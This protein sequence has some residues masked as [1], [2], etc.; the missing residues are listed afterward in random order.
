MIFARRREALRPIL[1]SERW[2]QVFESGEVALHP[3]SQ[4][5]LDA[6]TLE[7]PSVRPETG[8]AEAALPYLQR[9]SPLLGHAPDMG[10]APD[11]GQ[12]PDMTSKMNELV[13]AVSGLEA[14]GYVRPGPPIP[15]Q[16]DMPVEFAGL[17]A[18]A[19][20]ELRRVALIGDL[21]LITYMQCRPLF[22][23][24]V[25]RAPD[26][27]RPEFASTT[28]QLV[29]RGYV[30]YEMPGCLIERPEV[31]GGDRPARAI[32]REDQAAVVM[33][34]WLGGDVSAYLKFRDAR[35]TGEQ[36]E[37]SQPGVAAQPAPG[38]PT[39]TVAA[40]FSQLAQLTLILPAG[41]QVLLRALAVASGAGGHWL[42]VGQQ[43]EVA[44]QVT[45]GQLGDRLDEMLAAAS[46]PGAAAP[47]SGPAAG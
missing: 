34:G 28:W 1:V 24:E 33:L 31:H 9:L 3:F 26:P 14:A 25:H 27:A 41:K 18:A 39:A 7:P 10:H 20:G 38:V 46:R 5:E 42:L 29:A 32:L 6:V 8:P 2:R 40:G 43:L 21:G 11:V 16:G 4:V 23:A 35:T 19:D 36:N 45:L 44:T 47:P 17:A 12:A 13:S 15:P 22:V 37:Q 30:P